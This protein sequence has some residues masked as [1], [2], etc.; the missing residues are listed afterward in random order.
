MK[1]FDE[2][3]AQLGHKQNSTPKRSHHPKKPAAKKEA[4]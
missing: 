1:E 2:K 4:S 3:L